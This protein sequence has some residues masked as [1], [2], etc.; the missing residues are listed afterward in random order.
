MIRANDL[1][2]TLSFLEDVAIYEWYE[3]IH[4]HISRALNTT[5]R[6]NLHSNTFAQGV[7]R[8]PRNR[9]VIDCR[10]M[11]TLSCVCVSFVR[12]VSQVHDD[13]AKIVVILTASRARIGHTGSATAAIDSPLEKDKK[14]TNRQS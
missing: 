12:K 9:C 6:T 11:D 1:F 2:A 8:S 14:L 13:T 5:T 10:L 4:S 7:W 3:I